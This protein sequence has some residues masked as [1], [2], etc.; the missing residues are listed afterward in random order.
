[1]HGKNT[2]RRGARR[3]NGVVASNH[4]TA[5]FAGYAKRFGG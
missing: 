1:M 3:E 2:A 5:L 4:P